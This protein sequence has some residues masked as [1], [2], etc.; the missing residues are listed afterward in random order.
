MPATPEPQPLAETPPQGGPTDE[1]LA[2]LGAKDNQSI[3]TNMAPAAQVPFDPAAGLD[4]VEKQI[5]TPIQGYDQVPQESRPTVGDDKTAQEDTPEGAAARQRIML[6]DETQKAMQAAADNELV[7]NAY[8]AESVR[9]ATEIQRRAV[10]REQIVKK[11]QGDIDQTMQMVREGRVRP[12]AFW[13]D[14]STSNKVGH[15]MMLFMSGF[16]S[17]VKGGDNKLLE[18]INHLID[19]NID[20]QKAN[21][22]NNYNILGA[23]RGGVADELGASE[24]AQADANM[25][26]LASIESLKMQVMARAAKMPGNVSAQTRA[27]M[28]TDA[29]QQKQQALAQEA[30]QRAADDEIKRR[31]AY[32][33]MI[34]KERDAGIGQGSAGGTG[35]SGSGVPSTKVTATE[36]ER[37]GADKKLQPLLVGDG[38]DLSR[39]KNIDEAVKAG[40]ITVAKSPKDAEALAK[41]SETINLVHTRLRKAIAVARGKSMGSWNKDTGD[42]L[43]AVGQVKAALL[44]YYDGNIKQVEFAMSSIFGGQPDEKGVVSWL[45]DKVTKGESEGSAL[46]DDLRRG[47]EFLQ[48]QRDNDYIR[49]AGRKPASKSAWDLTM[50]EPELDAAGRA[51]KERADATKVAKNGATP[52]DRSKAINTMIGKGLT[53]TRKD[54]RGNWAVIDPATGAQKPVANRDEALAAVDAW[55]TQIAEAILNIPD[56]KE[57]DRLTAAAEK[58]YIATRNQILTWKPPTRPLV[59][60]ESDWATPGMRTLR[61]N[62]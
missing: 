12:N 42:V 11:Y 23:L 3:D 57:R 17:H 35:G 48:E 59:T 62:K 33:D 15:A 36:W 61:I 38:T 52:A 32:A 43:Q 34:K 28:I 1:E 30:A 20:A 31:S 6:A 47:G 53:A 51:N 49:Y 2:A 26:G 39:F 22:A 46:A 44:D 37:L 54:E 27:K 5:A 60:G 24:R 55:R 58:Q 45:K 19:R 25:A 18:Q 9:Q 16:T 13:A 40:A 29:L 4:D 56:A 21:L 7:T 8:A 10:E 14:M 41:R 50:P